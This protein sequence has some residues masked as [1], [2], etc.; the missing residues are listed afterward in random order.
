MTS[1][2]PQLT[3]L[4]Q[5]RYFTSC[6]AARIARNVVADR[7]ERPEEVLACIA[8]GLGFTHISL[9]RPPDVVQSGVNI[10]KGTI[11]TTITL[12][13]KLLETIARK[14]PSFA[15]RISTIIE[16]LDVAERVLDKLLDNPP[17]ER[18]EDVLPPGKCNC[19]DQPKV[20]EN[21][22]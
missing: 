13:K 18:V 17:S 15:R 3:P 7:N 9:S 5:P 1:K 4:G 22:Q 11:K 12:T 10:S 21:G 6:D 14:F 16:A 2:K 8:K 20:K 19:K